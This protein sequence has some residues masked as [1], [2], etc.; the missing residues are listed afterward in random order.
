MFK[1]F[2]FLALLLLI[3][4]KSFTDNTK[5][6]STTSKKGSDFSNYIY[7]LYKININNS[8]SPIPL[9]DGSFPTDNFKH[10][11]SSLYNPFIYEFDSIPNRAVVIRSNISFSP[12]L[13]EVCF[14]ISETLSCPHDTNFIPWSYIAP[15]SDF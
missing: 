5:T 6:P 4:C 14:L 10:N 15:F 1:V 7:T 9:S 8:I 3:S 2:L 12:P 13:L 11:T